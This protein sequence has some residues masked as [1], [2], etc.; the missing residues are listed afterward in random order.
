MH[1][2]FSLLVS[3]VSL[4]VSRFSLWFI[5][6]RILPLKVVGRI[7]LATGGQ[8]SDSTELAEVPKGGSSVCGLG[9]SG[10]GGASHSKTISEFGMTHQSPLSSHQLRF[11]AA[12][13]HWE[14]CTL[15]ALS[16]F[17]L[18]GIGCCLYLGDYAGH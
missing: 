6:V 9:L 18:V 3:R 7:R 4:L 2:R 10:D 13:S 1:C 8:M 5:P 11:V 12:L 17:Y 14:R 16:R 15:A